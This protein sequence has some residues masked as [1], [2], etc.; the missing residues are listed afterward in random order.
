MSLLIPIQTPPGPLRANPDIPNAGERGVSQ[1][2]PPSVPSGSDGAHRDRPCLLSGV[3]SAWALVLAGTLAFLF[4]GCSLSYLLHAAAGQLRIQGR[5][6][7]VEQALRGGDLRAEEKE[8][9]LLVS[10]IKAFGES[11][12]G[13][14]ATDNYETVYLGGEPDPVYTVTAAHRT[15]LELVTWWFPIVGRMPYLGYFDPGKARNK[16]RH[17]EDQG[18]DVVIWAA[19]AYSTLG[20]FQDPVHRNLLQKETVDIAETI[21]HEMTHVTLYAKGQP[22]FNETLATLVGMTGALAF[23]EREFGPESPEA[24]KAR[25][26][27][28]DERLFSA[29]IDDLASRLIELYNGPFGEEETLSRREQI[30]AEEVTRFQNSLDR[31]ETDRFAGFGLHGMNNAYLISVALY[32]RHFNLFESVLHAQEGSIQRTLEVFRALSRQDGDLIERT[33]EWL[34]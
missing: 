17:L 28:H 33:R 21:L 13:L 7:P 32:H 25:S 14:R 19:E 29:F 12:L 6:L 3:R 16:K 27:L 26:V 22:A 15:R 1:T 24:R 5:A 2:T 20:W 10:R 18:L 11:K 30:Y 23:L 34:T 31:M 8:K 9:I 4:S